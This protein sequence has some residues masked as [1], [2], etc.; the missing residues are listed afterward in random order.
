MRNAM[1]SLLA[2]SF[3]ASAWARLAQPGSTIALDVTLTQINSTHAMTVLRNDHSQDVS[4]P[5]DALGSSRMTTEEDAIMLTETAANGTTTQLTSGLGDARAPGKIGIPAPYER[6][7]ASGNHTS[8]MDLTKLFVIPSDGVY[9][10]SF[11]LRTSG[12]TMPPGDETQAA[13]INGLR[14]IVVVASAPVQSMQLAKSK[15]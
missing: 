4:I 10:V 5:L 8:V 13:V 14:S 11:A 1:S 9:N 15:S 12:R 7:R 6:I 3:G 2:L